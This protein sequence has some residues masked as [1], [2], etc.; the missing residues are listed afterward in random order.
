MFFYF[1]KHSKYSCLIILIYEVLVSLVHLVV[2]TSSHSGLSVSLCYLVIFNTML[3]HTSEIVW[4]YSFRARI[5]VSTQ[6]GCVFA[7]AWHLGTLQ[8]WTTW[9]VRLLDHSGSMNLGSQSAWR[10]LIG[11][12]YRLD[13]SSLLPSSAISAQDQCNLFAIWRGKEGLTFVLLIS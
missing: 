5:K 6:G 12:T 3:T 8:S 2:S 11:T 7:S 13:F 4:G 1:F 9:S 10:W